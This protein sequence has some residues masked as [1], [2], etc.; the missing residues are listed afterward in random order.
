M[1]SLNWNDSCYNMFI[2]PR[3]LPSQSFY[4]SPCYSPMQIVFVEIL[5]LS[6]RNCRLAIRD[7][8]RNRFGEK[9]ATNTVS[10]LGT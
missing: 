7:I 2:A 5:T 9:Y 3:L 10:S 1:L 6:A 4:L 8:L